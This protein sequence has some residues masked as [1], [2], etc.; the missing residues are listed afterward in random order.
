MT[1]KEEY[2]AHDMATA[3]ADGFRAGQRAVQ[4]AGVPDVSAMARVL[5][6]RSAD[7]CNVDRADNWAMYG[8]EYIEDVQA[9]L[10][11]APTVEAEQVSAAARDVLAERQR[12]IN[13]E[14]WTPAHDDLYC[15][16]EL[17]R[18]AAAY[19]LNGANDDAPYIW[20]FAAK[21]WK[22]RDA[23][24]NYVRAAALILAEIERLDRVEQAKQQET[25]S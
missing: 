15:A 17:P 4:S 5:S 10:A 9:M 8:Q 16:A 14:A 12:Q 18:A 13:I 25:Q 19:I 6:D 2:T 11:S 21:W 24:A 20:P 22:P 7:A 3:A 1:M 23:R